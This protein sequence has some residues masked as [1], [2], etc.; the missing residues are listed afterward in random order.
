MILNNFYVF[1]ILRTAKN[2]VSSKQKFE[3]A[4]IN[5]YKEPLQC[6]EW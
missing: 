2:Q 6:Q 3:T 4:L 1:L 5:S